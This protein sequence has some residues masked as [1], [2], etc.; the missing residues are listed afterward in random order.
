[1]NKHLELVLCFLLIW[2]I[3]MVVAWFL[4]DYTLPY[5]LEQ[6]SDTVD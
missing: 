6:L 4:V 2:G 5:H 3:K 1:M